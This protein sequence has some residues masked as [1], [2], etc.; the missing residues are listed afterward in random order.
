MLGKPRA[1]Y[2]DIPSSA[3]S[4]SWGPRIWQHPRMISQWGWSLIHFSGD[5]ISVCY[6]LCGS[7]E[8]HGFGLFL[9][10]LRN[11]NVLFFGDGTYV[12][13]LSVS[14]WEEEDR[15]F[16]QMIRD[17]RTAVAPYCSSGTVHRLEAGQLEDLEVWES[18]P[19]SIKLQLSK[20]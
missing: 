3:F 16:K 5:V 1:P 15:Y 13:F 20:L 11:F 10:G 14:V 6:N 8:S 4:G 17:K 18:I 19:N 9:Q 2:S 7:S 12:P